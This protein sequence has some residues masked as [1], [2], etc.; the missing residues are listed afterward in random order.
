MHEGMAL[1]RKKTFFLILVFGGLWLGCAPQPVPPS[2]AFRQGGREDALARQKEAAAEEGRSQALEQ[3][4][5]ASMALAL[6]DLEL[7][8]YALRKAVATMTDFAADG[9]FAAV[10]GA[11]SRKEWKG[12]PYEKMGAYLTLGLFL[13]AKGDRGN[14]LAM[15][16]SALLADTGS[17]LERYQSDFVPAW[18]MSALAYQAEG[19]DANATR[20]MAR[21]VDARWSRHTVRLLSD[22]LGDLD[23][24][25][26]IALNDFQRV[27]VLL[28]ASLSGGVS[29]EARDP[30]KAVKATLSIAST[31][32]IEQQDLSSKERIHGLQRVT[33]RQFESMGEVLPLVAASWQADV[34]AFPSGVTDAGERFEAEM[35][36]LLEEPPNVVLLVERGVGPRKVQQGDYGEVLKIVPSGIRTLPP[37]IRIAEVRT[38]SVLLDSLTFQGTTRGGR[39]VDGFLHGKAVYK[40]ASFLSGYLLLELSDIARA[41]END[42]LAAVMTIA[43]ALLTISSAVT[44]PAADARGWELAPD[45]WHLVAGTWEPGEHLLQVDQ[46]TYT[47][48]VPTRG[49]VVALVPALAP[50]GAEVLGGSDG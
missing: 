38:P 10:V 30:D 27:Q 14:A 40:D 47:L 26:G 16:K 11:E 49:Q 24:P 31:L 23:I 37:G 41:T 1:I 19:E 43:G 17:R 4:R 15:Y 9:E 35:K 32:L 20:T 25:D 3:L 50:G 5:L 48:R 33:K 2:E 29:A 6:G 21:G 42:N 44:N 34:S 28:L 7:A 36:R 46:R 12:E 13:H 22:A 45:Q 39:G 18:I 8:E